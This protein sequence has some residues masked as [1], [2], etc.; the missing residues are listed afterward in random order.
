MTQSKCPVCG[1]KKFHVKNPDDDYDVYEFEC[2]D[3]VSLTALSTGWVVHQK[4][5][6]VGT[7]HSWFDSAGMSAVE[8]DGRLLQV[9]VHAVVVSLLHRLQSSQFTSRRAYLHF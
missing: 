9:H 5:Q 8:V 6:L 3:G 2:Q 7:A 1:C 4:I